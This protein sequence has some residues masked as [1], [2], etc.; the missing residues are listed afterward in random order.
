MNFEERAIGFPCRESMLYGI[1]SLPEQVRSR[2]VLILVGGPQYRAG[3]H[4]QFTLLARGLAAQGIPAMRFDYRGMGDSEGSIRNFE[5]V[6][7]DLRAAID[8]FLAAVPGMTEIAIWGL[9]DGASAALFYAFQDRRVTGL[10]L[11]NPWVRTLDGIAKTTLKHYYRGRLLEAGFWKKILSGK[12]EY[13]AAAKSFFKLVG[14][15]FSV[16]KS[17]APETGQ[18]ISASVQRAETLPDRMFAGFNQFTGK[19]LLI[20]SG[21]DLTAQEFSDMVK[22][23]SKWQR[24]LAAARVNQKR[25]EGADHTF[26]RRVWRDQVCNW[27]GDW[28]RSW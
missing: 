28:I 26:S 7:D 8:Q 9:C 23:S 24:L 16:N 2:G 20:I 27:T 4:R 14:S 6:G 21:A 12:F 11:L 25:L 5:D 15:A 3:S 13:A 19:V 1:V 17:D 22:A 18:S 10:V